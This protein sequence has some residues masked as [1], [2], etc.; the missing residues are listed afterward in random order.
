ML[1][2]LV[3]LVLYPLGAIPRMVGP[4]IYGGVVVE[5]FGSAGDGC[6]DV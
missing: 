1:F 5:V 3:A 2:A 6:G 4:W